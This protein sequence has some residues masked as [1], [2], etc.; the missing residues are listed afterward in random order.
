MP[1]QSNKHYPSHLGI[2]QRTINTVW[3]KDAFKIDIKVD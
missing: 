3:L 1:Q 2:S